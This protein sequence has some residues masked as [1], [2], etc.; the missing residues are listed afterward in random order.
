VFAHNQFHV[1]LMIF[2]AGL[3]IVRDF[4]TGVLAAIIIYAMLHRYFD[5]RRDEA[6]QQVSVA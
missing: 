1:W 4:L 6:A 2:T 5:R 3:V